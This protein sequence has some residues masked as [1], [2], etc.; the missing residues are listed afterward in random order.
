[1]DTIALSG[2]KENEDMTM[3]KRITLGSDSLYLTEW[4]GE[5]VPAVDTIK[6][7]ANRLGLISGGATLEYTKDTYTAKD[8]LEKAKKTVITTESATIKSGVITWDADT[9]KALCETARVEDDKQTGWRTVKIGGAD[10]ADG[11]NY[12]LMFYHRDAADGDK[13]VMIVGRNNAGFSLAFAK[14]KETTIDAEF[15]ALP[16]DDEGTLLIYAEMDESIKTQR[17][18]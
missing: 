14:D 9:L 7:E 8:D 10:N 4:D 18:A 5:T 3:K 17:T 16:M 12:V 15:E 11:K 6:T 1:M 2:G 13:Y